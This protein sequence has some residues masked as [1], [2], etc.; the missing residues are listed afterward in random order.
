MNNGSNGR[1]VVGK[2]FPFDITHLPKWMQTLPVW[3]ASDQIAES[4]I[5]SRVTVIVSPTGS[6]KSMTIFEMIKQL[7]NLGRLPAGEAFLAQPLVE[8]ASALQHDLD[9]ML[10]EPVNLSTGPYKKRLGGRFTI[11]TAGSLMFRAGTTLYQVADEAHEKHIDTTILLGCMNL[12][13]KDDPAKK[14]IVMTATLSQKQL[15]DFR[16]FYGTDAIG[17]IQLPGRQYKLDKTVWKLEGRTFPAQIGAFVKKIANEAVPNLSGTEN[18]LVFVPSPKYFNQLIDGI[19]EELGHDAREFEITSFSGSERG[20]LINVNGRPVKFQRYI[21][22][23]ASPDKPSI[24]FTTDVIRTGISIENVRVSVTSGWQVRPWYKPERG[25]GGTDEELSPAQAV[26]QELGRAARFFDGYGFS[27]HAENRPEEDVPAIQRH[28]LAQTVLRLVSMGYDPYMFP[29]I[30]KPKPGAIDDSVEKLREIGAFEATNGNGNGDSKKTLLSS[31]GQAMI[32]MNM[33][34]HNARQVIQGV[35]QDC[36]PEALIVTKLAQGRELMWNPKSAAKWENQPLSEDEIETKLNQFRDRESD[37]ITLL[38]IWVEWTKN[39]MNGRWAHENCVFGKGL[40]DAAAGLVEMIR[41]INGV[42]F[43]LNGERFKIDIVPEDLL[44]VDLSDETLRKDIGKAILAG[45][46]ANLFHYYSRNRYQSIVRGTYDNYIFPGSSTF[47]KKPEWLVAHFEVQRNKQSTFWLKYCHAVD[48]AWI[49]QVAPQLFSATVDRSW[50]DANKDVVMARRSLKLKEQSY[51]QDEV[52]LHHGKTAFETFVSEALVNGKAEHPWKTI[53]AEKINKIE[54]LYVRS[55]GNV[56]G[57][58]DAEVMKRFYAGKLEPLG[59]PCSVKAM[60]EAGANLKMTD[61]EVEQLLGM[62]A[63]SLASIEEKIERVRPLTFL[64]GK[65]N[66]PIQYVMESGFSGGKLM[67]SFNLGRQLQAEHLPQLEGECQIRIC[68]TD[69]GYTDIFVSAEQIG[70]LTGKIEERRIEIAWQQ[71]RATFG[72]QSN[73]GR[74]RA[75]FETQFAKGFAPIEVTRANFGEGD[76]VMAYPGFTDDG[77]NSSSVYHGVKL[78]ATLDEALSKSKEALRRALRWQMYKDEMIAT[79]KEFP[80]SS[81]RQAVQSQCDGV[82]VEYGQKLALELQTLDL[83]RAQV[84]IAEMLEEV[85]QIKQDAG[86]QYTASLQSIQEARRLLEQTLAGI[87]SV[88]HPLISSEVERI[89][90]FLDTAQSTYLCSLDYENVKQQ[91]EKAKADIKKLSELAQSRAAKK[92]EASAARESVSETLVEIYH[93]RG[94]FQYVSPE[95][96]TVAG[97]HSGNIDLAFNQ[98]RYDDV[99]T[100]VEEAWQFIAVV[101]EKIAARVEHDRVIALHLKAAYAN[102]GFFEDQEPEADRCYSM[103]PEHELFGLLL[104]AITSAGNE[105]FRVM[106]CRVDGR[107]VSW[108][109]ACNYRGRGK[110]IDFYIR[111]ATPESEEQYLAAADL[112]RIQVAPFWHKPSERDLAVRKLEQEIAGLKSKKDELASTEE[113]ME[114][115]EVTPEEYFRIVYQRGQDLR[116]FV[117][118]DQNDPTAVQSHKDNRRKA[119]QDLGEDGYD[120]YFVLSFAP[121]ERGLECIM[122]IDAMEAKFA[123][124]DR[125]EYRDIEPGKQYYCSGNQVLYMARRAMGILVNVHCPKNVA[126]CFQTQIQSKEAELRALR[127]SA[128]G[129]QTEGVGEWKDIGKRW[130]QCPNGH[131]AKAGKNATEVVCD[132]CG[133]KKQ[134]A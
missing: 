55:Q 118:P 132:E 45:M 102:T 121:G 111:V 19:K 30:D 26:E 81:I 35:V 87:D 38:R 104:E 9:A 3:T 56:I 14:N 82:A 105:W 58:L 98:H 60:V 52:E 8:T 133:A 34:P 13:F 115:M 128:S 53:N 31:I 80:D 39:G 32:P 91:V 108:L 18:L 66:C 5:K 130:W 96:E 42:E 71:A 126:A 4:L 65:E 88:N 20:R 79:S 12:A 74:D 51:G 125:P 76:P 73:A 134:L 85:K 22:E 6:G 129:A 54:A 68:V 40:E 93:G 23:G 1:I 110:E 64:I 33:E 112:A 50:Y 89:R 63:G 127:A 70:E 59:K 103:Y 46:P 77:D 67:V 25:Y 15:Q 27:V 7:M 107:A 94:D 90:G 16:E 113:G 109:E 17:V 69:E 83:A 41:S 24:I 10:G 119:A 47:A 36:L 75:W 123:V 120:M 84:L 44:D 78:F 101:R 11:G 124:Q 122:E 116:L 48:T 49:P 117:K 28:A 99:M 57:R 61:A 106:E 43:T 114:H 97:T 29:F 100:L 62:T 131:S 92:D 86:G 72:E 2:D 37:Y 21:K 95:D